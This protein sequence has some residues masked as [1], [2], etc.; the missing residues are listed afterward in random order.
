VYER[1]KYTVLALLADLGG[2]YGAIIL[3]PS[4]L[5]S[6]YASRML[7]RSVA[8]NTS[9]VKKPRDQRSQQGEAIAAHTVIVNAVESPTGLDIPDIASLAEAAR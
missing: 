4:Q 6:F 9:K 2:F 7:A 8:A 5:V 3:I 1:A